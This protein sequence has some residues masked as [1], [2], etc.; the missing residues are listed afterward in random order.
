VVVVSL[1]VEGSS[2]VVGGLGWV[3]VW[4]WLSEGVVA[5]RRRDLVGWW[6]PVL[7]VV[8]WRRRW[9]WRD[10]GSASGG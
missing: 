7:K 10:F 1:V 2:S 6:A 3:W 4:V 5:G 8:R 9:P